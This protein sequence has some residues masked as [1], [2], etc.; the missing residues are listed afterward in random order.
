M[1]S[2]RKNF[3]LVISSVFLV[4]GVCLIVSGDDRPKTYALTV[5]GA[6]G[7]GVAVW[8]RRTGRR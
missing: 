2:F 4:V 8:A 7:L 5:A 3:L 6:V 1:R